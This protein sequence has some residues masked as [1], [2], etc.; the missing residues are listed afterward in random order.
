M[1][2]LRS[3]YDDVTFAGKLADGRHEIRMLE[4]AIVDFLGVDDLYEVDRLLAFELQGID[5]ARL[6]R[7]VGVGID[8]VTF[9]DVR[10]LDLSKA[11]HH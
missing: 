1:P 6:K 8:L 4:I 10:T 7:D 3:A 11:L 9:D 2:V 5:L